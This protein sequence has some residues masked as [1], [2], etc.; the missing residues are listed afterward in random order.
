MCSIF[1]E[2][3]KL[4]FTD[5]LKEKTL[6]L[7]QH[8]IQLYQLFITIFRNIVYSASDNTVLKHFLG[9]LSQSIKHFAD[10]MYPLQK[11]LNLLN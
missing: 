9:L 11:E 4:K 6:K 7:T 3:I 5:I 10:L 8:K 2:M 1:I